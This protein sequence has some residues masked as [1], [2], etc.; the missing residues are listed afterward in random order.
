MRALA[1]ALLAGMAAAGGGTSKAAKRLAQAH[2]HYEAAQFP[3]AAAGFS[4]VLRLSPSPKL[5][6]SLGVGAHEGAILHVGH[7]RGGVH[8]T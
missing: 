5:Q 6:A 3:E 7:H 4:K 2:A 8:V 1:L